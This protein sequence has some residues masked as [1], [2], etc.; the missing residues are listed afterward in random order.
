MVW[1]F[2]F[3]IACSNSKGSLPQ[4]SPIQAQ[5][6]VHADPMVRGETVECA[7]PGLVRCG[8][9]Q[10]EPW[11]RRTN[12]LAWLEE[13]WVDR[14]RTVDFQMGPDVALAW[15]EDPSV[16]DRLDLDIGADAVSETAARG[17]EA[18][19]SLVGA[20]LASIGLHGHTQV[21]DIPGRWGDVELAASSDPCADVN[22]VDG[23][24]RILFE[25]SHGVAVLA[26]ELGTDILSVSS[27]IPRSMAG[28]V[29]AVESP[30]DL[31][32][33]I[34][35][36]SVEKRFLSKKKKSRWVFFR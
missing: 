25:H 9:L 31:D 14:G 18:I 3:L 22:E 6:I 19:D 23:A 13:R 32:V 24:E 4:Q 21:Q 12:N 10:G 15:A 8:D 35:R 26:E 29:A 7:S 34:S 17:R 28:K 5:L 1:W 33:T 16:T 30:D 36:P 2:P 27:H 11:V 20:G